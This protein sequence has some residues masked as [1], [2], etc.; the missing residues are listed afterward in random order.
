MADSYRIIGIHGLSSKPPEDVLAGWWEDSIKEGLEKT[1]GRDETDLPFELVYWADWC[2]RK[3]DDP[4]QMDEPYIK[5][6]RPLRSYQDGW[7]DE[8]VASALQVG[9]RPLDWAKRYLGIGWLADEVLERKLEDLAVYY[10]DEQQR[11]K[12]RQVLRA[13]ILDAFG[14]KRV[15]LIAHSMGSIVAHDVL[16]ELGQERPEL[17]IDHFVTI[18]SPLGLPHVKDEIVSEYGSARTPS[19]VSRWTNFADRRDPVSLDIHLSDDFKPNSR[20]VKVRDD[21]VA[22]SYVGRSEKPNPH[23]SYGYLRAPEMSRLIEA[24]I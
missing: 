2:G 6:T 19:V 3:P 10:E 12:L 5:A 13:S 17:V 16:R 24:F 15:M 18:G 21:L 14:K 7:R 4:R 8:V 9:A 22:N 1:C 20:G 23:K 11:T